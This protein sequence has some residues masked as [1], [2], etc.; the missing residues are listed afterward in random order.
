M[1]FFTDV[2]DAGRIRDVEELFSS[3]SGASEAS[4]GSKENERQV[5]TSIIAENRAR[6]QTIGAGS[7][8]ERR[9]GAR[10]FAATASSN[11][12]GT[13]PQLGSVP[14]PAEKVSAREASRLDF[15]TITAPHLILERQGASARG[16]GIVSKKR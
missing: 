3:P 9:A 12:V 7:A 4:S 8:A 1:S 13:T 2:R 14:N 15:A 16:Q 11:R 6:A 10:E 5:G